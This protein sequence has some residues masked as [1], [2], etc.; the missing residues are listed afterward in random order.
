MKRNFY[1]LIAVLLSLGFVFTKSALAEI[2]PQSI[3]MGP[4]KF[5]PTLGIVEKR[6]DNIF[7]Q[8]T[9]EFSSLITEAKPELKFEAQQDANIYT[10]TYKGDYGFFDSSSDD[11]YEDH[12]LDADVK[13]KVGERSDVNLVL[14]TAKLHDDRGEGGSEGSAALLRAFADKYDLNYYGLVW[15]YG[16]EDAQ[17]GFRFNVDM[18]DKEYQNNLALTEYRNREDEAFS[19]RFYGR[20]SGKTRFFLE[21]ASKDL[22]YDVLPLSGISL[23]SDEQSISLGAEWNITGKTMGSVKVGQTDKEFDAISRGNPDFVDWEAKVSWSPRTYST[24]ILTT[25][26]LPVET[27]GVGNFI[28]SQNLSLYWNHDW[29][30]DLGSTVMLNSGNDAYDQDVRDD[31]RTNYRISVSYDISRAINM[32]FSYELE[33]RDSSTDA[34]DSK[35]S[36]VA[37]SLNIG[38]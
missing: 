29:S 33:D 4:V 32:G 22:S 36:I 5:T 27:T 30:D 20:L 34:F 25:S 17:F 12:A 23:D 28:E 10:I 21:Y 19:A 2:D 16:V 35:T 38:L 18:T 37:L 1:T 31:D 24:F 13:L 9:S 6:N 15:D 8:P 7:S 26:K 3:D 11:N 14:S